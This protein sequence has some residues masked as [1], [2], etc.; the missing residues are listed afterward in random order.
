[1]EISKL[2][3]P[4][5]YWLDNKDTNVVYVLYMSFT[6]WDKTML[7]KINLLE[8][9]LHVYCGDN[10]EDKGIISSFMEEAYNS[11]SS[12]YSQIGNGY[13]DTQIQKH[14]HDIIV[15][16]NRKDPQEVNIKQ[17]FLHIESDKYQYV[18][19]DVKVLSAEEIV[20]LIEQN[21]LQYF[22]Y[23]DMKKSFYCGITNDVD[24][25]MEQHRANDFSIVDE[26]VCAYVCANVDVA[27]QVEGLLGEHGYDIGGRNAAGNGVTDTS[28]I[29]Y[30][31]KKGQI[32]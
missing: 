32:V 26:R 6:T 16:V 31:L 21:M 29:V 13:N 14:A 12:T 15:N 8:E 27:K 30:F 3:N 23:G 19:T 25:R 1:M 28:Y 10:E 9:S 4:I 20:E 2:D 7:A 11:E 17:L 5:S 24:T 22:V 18:Y